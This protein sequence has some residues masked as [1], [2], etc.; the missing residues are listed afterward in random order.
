MSSDPVVDEFRQRARIHDRARQDVRAGLGTFL[1]HDDGHF[2]AVLRRQLFQ[3]D[4]RRQAGRSA[5][6]DDDVVFHRLARSVLRQYFFVGHGGSVDN[7]FDVADGVD[8][9]RRVRRSERPFLFFGA[10]FR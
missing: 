8:S 6:N 10:Y 1:E 2:L 9:I 4:R 5:A 3:A 7:G